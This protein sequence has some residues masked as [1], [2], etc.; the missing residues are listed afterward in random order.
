MQHS[1]KLNGDGGGGVRA[2]TVIGSANFYDDIPTNIVCDN[3]MGLIYLLSKYG[4][5]YICDIESGVP[6]HYHLLSD[7]RVA[8]FSLSLDERTN[9][10]VA[11]AR[12]GQVSL[13]KVKLTA[14]IEDSANSK[15]Q[16]KVFERISRK[17]KENEPN[18][19]NNN[20]NNSIVSRYHEF[21]VNVQRINSGPLS[22]D[23][24]KLVQLN[25][26]PLT[27]SHCSVATIQCNSEANKSFDNSS[28]SFEEEVTRL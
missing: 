28:I 10:L 12:D 26:H 9:S 2:A 17:L 6:L 23:S 15:V 14:L 24:A 1:L 8:Y 21:C 13:I 18:L 19:N 11:L 5:F 25:N 16:S 4:S 20:N 22:L 27:P 3:R 7:S